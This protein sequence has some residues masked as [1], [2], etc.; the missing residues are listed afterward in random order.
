MLS[1]LRSDIPIVDAAVPKRVNE[2]DVVRFVQVLKRKHLECS[3]VTAV[4]PMNEGRRTVRILLWR[5]RLSEYMGQALA[6]IY[7]SSIASRGVSTF[8]DKLGIP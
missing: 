5:I 8:R 3:C 6:W 4:L 1:F 7:G 2:T